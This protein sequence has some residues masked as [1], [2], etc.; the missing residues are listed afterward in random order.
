MEISVWSLSVSLVAW[1]I[2]GWI[3]GLG[4]KLYSSDVNMITHNENVEVEVKKKYFWALRG[5]VGVVVVVWGGGKGGI[6]I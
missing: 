2:R 6:V 3:R 5:W 1:K 4:R